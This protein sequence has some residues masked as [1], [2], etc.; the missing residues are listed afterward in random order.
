[1][2]GGKKLNTKFINWGRQQAVAVAIFCATLALRYYHHYHLRTAMMMLQS[3]L[4]VSLYRYHITEMKYGK[5]ILILNA[6]SLPS[7]FHPPSSCRRPRKQT[8]SS[9]EDNN[10]NKKEKLPKQQNFIPS[11]RSVLLLL[12]LL[13]G[14][15]NARRLCQV[16]FLCGV[17][18]ERQSK[19]IINF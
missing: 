5:M 14:S 11:F 2:F 17:C 1:M 16:V 19:M 10:N 8:S 7:S 4:P 9:T 6:H 12:L 18:E 13:G 3:F 15:H